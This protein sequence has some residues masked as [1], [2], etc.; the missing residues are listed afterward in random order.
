MSLNKIVYDRRLTAAGDRAVLECC[1]RAREHEAAGDYETARSSLAAR[2]RGAGHH[3]HLDG[4]GPPAAAEL[5][6]RAGVLTG[7]LGS[8]Q[9]LAGAQET[10]KDLINEALRVFEEL[11]ER[12]RVAESRIELALCYWRE[13]AFDEGRVT[14]REALAQLGDSDQD[15]RARA[16]LRAVT[17]ER[18][19]G[20]LRAA[21]DMLADED[22]LFG[23]LEDHYLRGCFHNMRGLTYKDLLE[24]GAASDYGDRAAI[25]FTAASFHFEQS[26]HARYQASVEGNYGKLLLATG[27]LAEAHE[28]LSFARGLFAGLRDRRGAVQVDETRA[29]A[30]IADGRF[31]KAWEVIRYAITVLEQG[32]ER[33]LLAE[34]LTTGGVALARMGRPEESMAHLLRAIE[35]AETAGALRHAADAALTL[36][37]ESHQLLSPREVCD[38]YETADRLAGANATTEL[39]SRV[40]HCASL[41]PGVVRQLL[42]ARLPCDLNERVRLLERQHIEEALRVSGGRITRAARLLGFKHPQFLTS[43]MQSRHPDLMNTRRPPV[44]RR[45][46]Q[47]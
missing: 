29:R 45:R 46:K 7:W 39:L 32:G 44:R 36:I 3:P 6:L 24:G 37:E 27:R 34:A 17:I 18:S 41:L 13:G 16:L 28:H 20:Q 21:L 10:A 30:F 40:R 42:T 33:A 4:L 9:Q 35:V 38:A 8:A 11:G 23:S 15:W 43:I 25:E 14:L 19:D 5:L 22:M 1:A 12:E 47:G 31:D 2:W 26:G